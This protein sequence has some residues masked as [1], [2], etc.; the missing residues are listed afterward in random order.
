MRFVIVAIVAVLMSYPV[1]VIVW[2][3]PEGAE[4]L[5]SWPQIGASL[6]LLPPDHICAAGAQP[7]APIYPADEQAGAPAYPAAISWGVGRVAAPQTWP[8]TRGEGVTVAVLDSGIAAHDDLIDRVVSGA[9]FIDSDAGDVCGHGTRVAGTVAGLLTGVAPAVNLMPVKV[10]GDQCYGTYSALI[11]GVLYAADAGAQIINISLTGTVDIPAL[12]AAVEYAQERGAL[13]IAAAGNT[14]TDKPLYPAA[15]AL[16]VT[17]TDAR[18]APYWH[19]SYGPHI[20]LGAPAVEIVTTSP[21]G[22]TAASGTSFAAPHVAGAAALAWSLQ[23]DMTADEVAKLLMLSAADC[24]APGWD[25][26]CGH[27]RVD[28]WAAARDLLHAVYLPVTGSW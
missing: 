1:P 21:A 3:E 20:D 4:V 5:V 9:S 15:Y 25:E 19:N 12:R 23:P 24:G 11:S 8:H 6:V 7:D 27:G 13:V 22:Y 10:L 16:T 14:G 28:A 18:D 17:G 26:Q 2:G